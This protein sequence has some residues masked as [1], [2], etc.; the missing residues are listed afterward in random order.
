MIYRIAPEMIFSKE[1]SGA[2]TAEG[3][4]DN[5]LL[6]WNQET[7]QC[8]LLTAVSVT[9]SCQNG[10]YNIFDAVDAGVLYFTRLMMSV[11]I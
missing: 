6:W 2:R 4:A 9:D 7:I 10:F 1:I 5:I 3:P 8:E 11:D